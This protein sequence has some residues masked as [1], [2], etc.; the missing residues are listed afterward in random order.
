VYKFKPNKKQKE[1]YMN[2]LNEM[3]KIE[4]NNKNV[5][6][7]SNYQTAYIRKNDKIIRISNHGKTPENIS[8]DSKADIWISSRGR[9][10]LLTKIKDML[11]K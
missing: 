9:K 6:F 1:E 7:H 11:N 3:K 2:I 8:Y 5:T 10:D 4:S